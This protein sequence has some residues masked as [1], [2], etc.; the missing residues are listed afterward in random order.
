MTSGPLFYPIISPKTHFKILQD[1]RWPS[2]H[3]TTLMVSEI[4][5]IN[6]KNTFDWCSGA[7][8]TINDYDRS[9]KGFWIPKFLPTIPPKQVYDYIYG[10]YQ[11]KNTDMINFVG[12]F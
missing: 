9:W 12:R 11:P 5:Y 1:F 8:E 6:T 2:G 3:N 10:P 7:S 4:G